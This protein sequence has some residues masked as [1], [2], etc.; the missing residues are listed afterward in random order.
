MEANHKIIGIRLPPDFSDAGEDWV[1]KYLASRSFPVLSDS[2]P[3]D[4]MYLAELVH[5]G[6][7]TSDDVREEVY[8]AAQ[9]AVEY[10]ERGCRWL[11][12]SGADVE[13]IKGTWYRPF[14][15]GLLL[16]LLLGDSVRLGRLC[17]W[18]KP[19]RRLEDA[20]PPE[21]DEIQLLYL[22]LAGF[23]QEQPDKRF[24]K[25]RA[26]IAA[27]R[28]RTV[29]LLNRALD[30]VVL[31]NQEA[32]AT[33]IE[34]C[35]KHHKTRPDATSLA[36]WRPRHANA[37]FLAGL[38]LGLGRPEYPPEIAAYLM[39]PESVGLAPGREPGKRQ[40]GGAGRR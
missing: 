38:H 5:L 24:Q 39:T 26:K 23:F 22:V 2:T 31:R 19:T 6:Y 28:T 13:E 40:E 29:R 35:V 27:C 25:L 8:R 3:T 9:W 10:F 34:S 21:E 37:I 11:C 33:A 4:G 17:A 15:S 12:G 14:S 36:D 32:F 16:C 30:A 18:A 20:Y 1:K 7:A